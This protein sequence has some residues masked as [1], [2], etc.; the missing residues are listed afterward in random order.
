MTGWCCTL[1]VLYQC[2]LDC[3]VYQTLWQI[4]EVLFQQAGH[5]TGVRCRKIVHILAAL[6]ALLQGLHSTDIAI[7]SE[8]ALMMQC[9]RGNAKT[10]MRVSTR[11]SITYFK[12]GSISK[13]DG[14]FVMSGSSP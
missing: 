10:H 8:Q 12:N 3:G 6:Q 13:A 2:L 5:G 7:Y 14:M 4:S 9:W 11:K 1:V